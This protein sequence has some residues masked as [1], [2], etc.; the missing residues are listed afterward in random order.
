MHWILPIDPFHLRTERFVRTL[1]PTRNALSKTV[2]DSIQISFTSVYPAL[3]SPHSA[4]PPKTAK[5]KFQSSKND[6]QINAAFSYTNEVF[7]I[8]SFLIKFSANFNFSNSK[9]HGISLFFF[10][11]VRKTKHEQR[12]CSYGCIRMHTSNRIHPQLCGAAND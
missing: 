11:F 8:S 7:F 2:R 5:F 1:D 6:S 9:I 12:F 10:F 3:P 4:P